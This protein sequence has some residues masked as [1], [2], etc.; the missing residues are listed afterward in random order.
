MDRL[1]PDVPIN[2]GLEKLLAV[3]TTGIGSS[4]HTLLSLSFLIIPISLAVAIKI[5][6]WLGPFAALTAVLIPV[7]ALL[8]A[9]ACLGEDGVLP[10]PGGSL[11]ATKV[12]K[13]VC[14]LGSNIRCEST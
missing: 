11:P 4:A 8:Y 6:H 12:G 1:F 14:F 2:A 10:T 7:A 5:F 9:E 3:M 13:P